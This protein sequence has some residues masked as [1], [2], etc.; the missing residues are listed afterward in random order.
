MPELRSGRPRRP[1]APGVS[2]NQLT[3]PHGHVC[4]NTWACGKFTGKRTGSLRPECERVNAG[5]R[6]RRPAPHGDPDLRRRWRPRW[7]CESRPGRGGCLAQRPAPPREPLSGSAPPHVAL[8][9]ASALDPGAPPG[10]SEKPALGSACLCVCH[11][12]FG[13]R[14]PRRSLLETSEA[15]LPVCWH[16]ESPGTRHSTGH[17]RPPT[18]LDQKQ[19][20]K[21]LLLLRLNGSHLGKQSITALKISVGGPART[22]G[23]IPLT[24]RPFFEAG[25]PG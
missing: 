20:S 11:R 12:A 15:E 7:R 24:P 13:S 18:I 17:H 22:R 10:P 16:P 3:Q 6:G 2:V 9:V 23:L 8:N 1:G 14:P 25:S 4:T 5:G 19:A 21:L